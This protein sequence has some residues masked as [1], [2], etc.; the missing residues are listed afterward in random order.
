MD[1]NSMDIRVEHVNRGYV[2]GR[3]INMVVML[4]QNLKWVK[5][6]F[7][8]LTRAFDEHKNSKKNYILKK[9]LVEIVVKSP[10]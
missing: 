1:N 2:V 8:Y 10:A 4:L 9:L 3:T 5:W 7:L 6:H